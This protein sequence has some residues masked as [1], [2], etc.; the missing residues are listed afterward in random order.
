MKKWHW[1]ILTFKE[2]FE[3]GITLKNE[4][5]VFV[6]MTNFLADS[7]TAHFLS[8]MQCTFSQG[9]ICHFCYIRFEDMHRVHCVDDTQMRKDYDYEPPALKHFEESGRVTDRGID[10]L[11]AR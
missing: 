7:L 2:M 8:G 11:P 9:C 1:R 4:K 6:R 3:K 10:K 5:R